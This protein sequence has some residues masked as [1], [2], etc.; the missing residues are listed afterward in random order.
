[1]YNE[2]RQKWK[3]SEFDSK[4]HYIPVKEWWMESFGL[5]PYIVSKGN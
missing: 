5:S 3:Q 1:M 4:I 2:V